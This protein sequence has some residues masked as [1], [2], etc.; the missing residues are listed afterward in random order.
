MEY[1][2]A[3]EALVVQLMLTLSWF[4]ACETE[5]PKPPEP[6]KPACE[7]SLDGLAGKTFVN[8]AKQADGTSK[9]DIWAR[10]HFYDEGGKLKLKYNTR[11]MVDMYTYSC[12]KENKEVFCAVD[13]VDADQYCKTLVA[14]VGMCTAEAVAEYTGQ[15]LEA[16]RKAKASVDALVKKLTPEQMERFKT[17]FSTPNNQLRGV[18]H[19]KVHAADCVLGI[20]DNYETMSF[21][22][23]REVGNVV[24]AAKFGQTDRDLVF[25]QCTDQQSLI[26]AE[27]PTKTYQVGESKI[28]WT[29][30]TPVPFKVVG[31][32]MTKAE[33]DCTYSMDTWALFEP[34]SKGTAVTP[35]EKGQLE[36]GFSHAFDTPGRGVVHM[37]R[38]KA[39]A[40]STAAR[41]DVLCGAVKVM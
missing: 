5:P 39:C 40:G 26:A 19:A 11:A 24:G 4:L 38:Y 7:L 23:L 37:Y 9:E 31:K 8:L 16:T 18:F 34:L 29:K 32:S 6:E 28:E 3:A 33:K 30:D 25:E 17:Q 1:N 36:W 35:N 21:G 15:T 14:N 22:Q 12:K 13:D 27:D 41:V 2:G 20:T 10:A